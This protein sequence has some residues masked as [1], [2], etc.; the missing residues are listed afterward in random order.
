[1]RA[2]GSLEDLVQGAQAAHVAGDPAVSAKLTAEGLCATGRFS[3]T[4][5]CGQLGITPPPATPVPTQT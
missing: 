1:M 2:C 4:Q 5:I 3:E